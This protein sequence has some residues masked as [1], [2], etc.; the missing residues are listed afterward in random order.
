[1]IGYGISQLIR[2]LIK[3]VFGRGRDDDLDAAR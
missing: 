1:V 3:I 2:G